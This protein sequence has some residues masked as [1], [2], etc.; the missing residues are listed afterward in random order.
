MIDHVN[1]PI[2]DKAEDDRGLM[3]Y[4]CGCRHFF[5]VYTKARKNGSIVRRKECRHCGTRITTVEKTIGDWS[6]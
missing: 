4:R 3:C 2:P 6:K 1:K 5:V